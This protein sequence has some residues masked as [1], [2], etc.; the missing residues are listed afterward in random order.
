MKV[1]VD[2]NVIVSALLKPAGKPARI[3]RL[4]IQGD[5]EVVISEAILAE[6]EEVLARPRFDLPSGEVEKI[7]SLIRSKG[8]RAPA[9]AATLNLPDPKDEAFLEAALATGAHA[10]VTGNKKH[11]PKPACKGQR[12]VSPAEFT[13]LLDELAS[14]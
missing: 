9:L 1:V 2:T 8:V 10:L 7:L 4:V 3:L 13:H 12:V 11:Y 5:L 14:E 6:Y